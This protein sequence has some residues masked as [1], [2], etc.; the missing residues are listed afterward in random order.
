M[1][2]IQALIHD[3]LP[4]TA[5]R[6]FQFFDEKILATEIEALTHMVSLSTQPIVFKR[7]YEKVLEST[8]NE[9]LWTKEKIEGISHPIYPGLNSALLYADFFQKPI[10][11]HGDMLG[12]MTPCILLFDLLGQQIQEQTEH[13][14]QDWAKTIVSSNNHDALMDTIHYLDNHFPEQHPLFLKRLTQGINHETDLFHELSAKLCHSDMSDPIGLTSSPLC[15][16]SA[17]F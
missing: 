11:G 10:Y 15:T 5:F 6:T 12:R 16:I 1:P 3:Q 13:S 17:I 2:F 8:K 4:L 14:L 9:H 7:Y